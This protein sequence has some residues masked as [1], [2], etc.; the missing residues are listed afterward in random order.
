MI[1]TTIA[2]LVGIG[3]QPTIEPAQFRVDVPHVVVVNPRHDHR[4]YEEEHRRHEEERHR[5]WEREHYRDR[6]YDRR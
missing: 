1:S 3:G 5:Y 6:D 4:R 2:L